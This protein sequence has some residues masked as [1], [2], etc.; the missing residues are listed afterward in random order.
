MFDMIYLWV[1]SLHVIAVIA[2]M[3]GM[4]Y[5]PRLFVYHCTAEIGSV[6]SETFKIMER[7]LVQGD[8]ESGDDGGLGGRALHRLGAELFHAPPGFTLSSPWWC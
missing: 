4:L 8:H 6:Q 7:R 2:W 3:A 1:K 5:M